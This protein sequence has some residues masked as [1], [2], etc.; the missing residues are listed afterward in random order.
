MNQRTKRI[1]EIE[2]LL[3]NLYVQGVVVS[4]Q[5][6]FIEQIMKNFYCTRKTAYDY[7]KQA[8]V[9]IKWM[10]KVLETQ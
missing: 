7:I 9:N 3:T 4:N 6:E 5:D 8:E 10:K 1:K 2:N